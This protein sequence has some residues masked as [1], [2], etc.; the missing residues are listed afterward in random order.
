MIILDTNVISEYI[1]SRPEERVADWFDS[2]DADQ[3]A[4][5]TVTIAELRFG[6]ALL[7]QGSRRVTLEQT[8]DRLIAR[9]FSGK[10]ED[11]DFAATGPYASVRAARRLSGNPIASQ[12]AQI[13]AICIAREAVLA[14]R[15]TKDFDGLGI[16]LINP[17][18]F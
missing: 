6:A 11:F 15:N 3:V 9:V 18:E 14:T 17:W 1:R 16:T 4:T 7:P 2:V 12:D 8:I 5:T 10:I 13:A